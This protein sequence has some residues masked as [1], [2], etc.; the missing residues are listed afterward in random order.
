MRL[1]RDKRDSVT[2]E[3]KA[4][5]EGQVP[6]LVNTLEKALSSCLP[7]CQKAESPLGPQVKEW[8]TSCVTKA[9]PF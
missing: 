7:V 6:H 5:K 3:S 8:Q 2:V 9:I 4:E 1:I